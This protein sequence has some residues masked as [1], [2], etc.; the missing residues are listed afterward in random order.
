MRGGVEWAN[1][2][3]NPQLIDPAPN[4]IR[5]AVTGV[6]ATPQ[7]IDLG[8]VGDN[9]AGPSAL[10]ITGNIEIDGPTGSGQ[11]VTIARAAGPDMRLFDVATVGSLTLN[12]LTLSGGVAQGGPAAAVAAA[13]AA[14]PALAGR[15]ST[16]AP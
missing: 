9:T 7:T 4:V 16:R 14:A 3:S 13:A 12:N 6:F 10:G 8:I 11:G 1:A 5:F 2:S 15:S